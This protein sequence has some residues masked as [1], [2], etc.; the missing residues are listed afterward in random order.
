M[1]IGE[2]VALQCPK[3]GYQYSE[4]FSPFHLTEK[5]HKKDCFI[6]KKPF[7]YEVILHG[8]SFNEVQV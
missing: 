5:T 6:C 2:S 4:P 1:N 3:C 7:T 8:E